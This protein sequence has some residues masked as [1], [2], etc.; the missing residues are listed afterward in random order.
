MDVTNELN[1]IFDQGLA[2]YNLIELPFLLIIKASIL[3]KV[4]F[5]VFFSCTF[6]LFKVKF[7]SLS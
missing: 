7:P 2:L 3:S 1:E 6:F 5:V 4:V